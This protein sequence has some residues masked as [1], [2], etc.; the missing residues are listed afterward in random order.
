MTFEDIYLLQQIELLLR[1]ALRA[2]AN[3]HQTPVPDHSACRPASARPLRVRVSEHEG[4]GNYS[5][6]GIVPTRVLLFSPMLP[7]SLPL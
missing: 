6:H 1:S 5:Y 3:I 7:R 4:C 2:G